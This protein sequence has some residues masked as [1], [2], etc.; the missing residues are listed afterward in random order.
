V[1]VTSPLTPVA[2]A[3]AVDREPAIEIRIGRVDV[4]TSLAPG[5]PVP[6]SADTGGGRAAGATLSLAS[7]LKGDGA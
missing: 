7:Y 1:V 4:R 2:A 5:P 3:A 6:A